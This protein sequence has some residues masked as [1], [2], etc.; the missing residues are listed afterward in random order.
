M[1]Q[2]PSSVAHHELEHFVQQTKAAAA[3]TAVTA[4]NASGGGSVNGLGVKQLFNS[5]LFGYGMGSLAALEHSLQVRIKSQ[6]TIHST[7]L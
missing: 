5:S 3:V 6:L 2:H 7:I 1:N 4:V